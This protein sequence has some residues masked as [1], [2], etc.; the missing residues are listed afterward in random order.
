MTSTDEAERWRSMEEVMADVHRQELVDKFGV[1]IAR[2][3]DA[4]H[5]GKKLIDD[6]V[7]LW[8][9]LEKLL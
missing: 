7:T 2:L 9:D 4:K 6:V 1:A 8:D 5:K 3:R